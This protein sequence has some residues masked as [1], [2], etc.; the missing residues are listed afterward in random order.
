MSMVIAVDFDGTIVEHDYPRIGR[1]MPGAFVTMKRLIE[2]G[3]KLILY[4]M[5]SGKELQAAV[6]FCRENGVE[7]WGVNENPEQAAWTNSRKVY[8]HFYIDD[9]AVMAPL[10]KVVDPDGT[11]HIYYDWL[12]VGEFLEA[13]KSPQRIVHDPNN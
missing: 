10:V 2:Q 4:T 3:W 5:R 1:E 11:A 13:S 7:F 12:K 9:A 8:A 6:D